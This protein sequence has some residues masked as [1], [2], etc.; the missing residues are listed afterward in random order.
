MSIS[1]Q[2]EPQFARSVRGYDR[3][4]VDEYV[5]SVREYVEELETRAAAAEAAL[6][7]CRRELASPGSGG[8]SE[9][10]AAILQ[11]ANEEAEEVRAK[12][13]ADAVTVTNHAAREAEDMISA[14]REQRLVLQQEIDRQTAI[15][16]ELLQRLA[17]LAAMVDEARQHY[18]APGLSTVA[19][20][21]DVE[22]FDAEA[23]DVDD[24]RE[25]GVEVNRESRA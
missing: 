24:G 19:Q 2:P 4:D 1:A 7:E 10:L 22:L 12:A 3:F 11:L 13:A 23:M 20:N 15:R 25:R 5:V 21:I 18:A 9:R 8:I 17:H 14:A 16:D 6:L